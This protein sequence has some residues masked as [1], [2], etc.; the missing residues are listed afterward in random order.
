[1]NDQS[2]IEKVRETK[3]AGTPL[4][5]LPGLMK[6]KPHMVVSDI[7]NAQNMIKL[8]SNESALGLSPKALMAAREMLNHA[9]QY[10]EYGMF[11]LQQA[12]ADCFQLNPELIVCGNGSDDLLSRLI[13]AF[14]KPGDEVIR[15]ANGYAKYINYAYAVNATPIS[16]PDN[17]FRAD[18]QAILD[19]VTPRTRIVML[20]NP[21]NP[22]GSLVSGHELRS[23]HE[24]LPGNVLLL[25]DSAYAEYVDD[26]DYEMPADLIEESGNVVMT[27]TFSKLF[28]MAGLRLGWLYG[29][30]VIVD[31]VTRIGTTF[32]VS[33]VA[34]AAGIAATK[35]L[36][37][38]NTV[39]KHN[40]KW[41]AWLSG[42][43]QSLGLEVYPSDANFILVHFPDSNKHAQ[44]AYVFL[45]ERGYVT[46]LFPQPAFSN[47]MRITIG[48]EKDMKKVS[49]YLE[50]FLSL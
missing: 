13:R 45:R 20:A 29:S 47:C 6:I 10:F 21:D 17:R 27:R 16:V 19:A 18:V 43:L 50:E 24:S 38:I 12:I 7:D 9:H 11:E 22:T 14:V 49:S 4:T 31:A 23:L 15:S 46:R 48:Y 35:D 37:H 32:P 41:R 30:P 44:D 5:A 26:P 28:G 3:Q 34:A 42:E 36:E 2:Q 39:Q 8:C 25:L 1:M 33:N 40:K